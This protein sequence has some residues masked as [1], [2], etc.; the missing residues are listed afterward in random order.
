M[1]SLIAGKE[2]IDYV[3]MPAEFEDPNLPSERLL[4]KQLRRE[5]NTLK[6][7]DPEA[8]NQYEEFL[9]KRNAYDEAILSPVDISEVKTYPGSEKGPMPEDDPENYSRWFIENQPKQI[10]P[11]GNNH[12][13]S[14]I[15]AKRRYVQMVRDMSE[16]T[17]QKTP[18][19]YFVEE[20]EL[21]P[22]ASY[23]GQP[24]FS[25]FERERYHV[26]NDDELPSVSLSTNLAPNELPPMPNEHTLNYQEVHY[27]LERW[28]I[29]RGLPMMMKFDQV[30]VNYLKGLRQGTI[31]VPDFMNT[32]NPPSLFAYYETLPQWARDHPAVRNVL[33]AFEYH[34]PTLDIRQKELAMNYAMS[35]IRPIDKDLEEVIIEVATS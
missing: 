21:Y 35:F 3:N 9:F 14:D 7:T 13:Y 31:R 34:K 6:L 26:E 10:Y 32:I 4:A 24:E 19:S 2:G 12:D 28:S 22:L 11:D 17:E 1:K 25:V 18:L 27:E 29:F 33:M 5:L 8:A 23:Q 30:M 15:G 20:D 16:N